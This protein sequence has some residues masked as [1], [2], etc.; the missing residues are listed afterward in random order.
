[1]SNT[2]RKKLLKNGLT[3]PT[4]NNTVQ[5]LDAMD[6]TN[7]RTIGVQ[8]NVAGANAAGTA[9]LQWSNDGTNWDDVPSGFGTVTV[10]FTTAATKF[11]NVSSIGISLLRVYC[12]STD[13]NPWVVTGMM[14]AKEY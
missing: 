10:T 2:I 7:H 8:V 1:M 3:P 14:I 6:I 4:F 9:K 11:L 5:A 12:T 13:T